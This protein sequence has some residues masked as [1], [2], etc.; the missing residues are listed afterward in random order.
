MTVIPRC[1]EKCAHKIL[2][3]Q[4]FN[5]SRLNIRVRASILTNSEAHNLIRDSLLVMFSN[6]QNRGSVITRTG[7][8]V[9]VQ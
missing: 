1:G 6:H 9:A 8:K 5:Q 2:L 4:D 7:I 3:G